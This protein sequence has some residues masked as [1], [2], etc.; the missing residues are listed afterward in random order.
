LVI[1]FVLLSIFTVYVLE[2]R[3]CQQRMPWSQ[4]AGAAETRL[5][6]VGRP[7]IFATSGYNPTGDFPY[8]YNRDLNQA[9]L[10]LQKSFSIIASKV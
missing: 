7:I 10:S 3:S 8:V 4:V 6:R 2:L 9:Q 5:R 1:E